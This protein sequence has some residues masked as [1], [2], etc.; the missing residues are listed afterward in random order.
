ML[1]PECMSAWTIYSQQY[2]LD[3]NQETTT[4]GNTNVIILIGQG[5]D[6]FKIL[7]LKVWHTRIAKSEKKIFAGAESVL[8]FVQLW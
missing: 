4:E 3:L 6:C 7:M 1:Q 8:I 2:E 5:K